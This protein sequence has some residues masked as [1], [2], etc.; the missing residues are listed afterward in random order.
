[1][2]DGDFLVCVCRGET[3]ACYNRKTQVNTIA[4]ESTGS[5]PVVCNKINIMGIH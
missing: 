2:F 5:A 4:T 1:M 3:G